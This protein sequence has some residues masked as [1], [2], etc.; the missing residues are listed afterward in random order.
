MEGCR[1][2]RESALE[3]AQRDRM[4]RVVSRV[5][6]LLPAGVLAERRG[7]PAARAVREWAA[8]ERAAVAQVAQVAVARALA[9][10]PL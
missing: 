5:R 2:R 6:V 1:V 4:L 3:V 8:P 10:Q 9:V 7:Q